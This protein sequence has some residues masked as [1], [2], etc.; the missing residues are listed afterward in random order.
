MDFY[1]FKIFLNLKGAKIKLGNVENIFQYY[2]CE[3]LAIFADI[4]NRTDF[5]KI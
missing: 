3:F 2:A 5:G 1:F 4:K